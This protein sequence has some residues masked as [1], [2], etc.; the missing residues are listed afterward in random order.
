MTMTQVVS[1]QKLAAKSPGQ[2]IREL[3]KLTRIIERGEATNIST[4]V[5]V[6]RAL[7]MLVVAVSEL[8]DA[9]AEVDVT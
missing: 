6:Q 3:Q 9:G 4:L 1:P 5:I 2:A 8:K 7:F